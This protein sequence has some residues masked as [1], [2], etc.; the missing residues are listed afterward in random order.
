MQVGLGVLVPASVNVRREVHAAL[1]FARRRGIPP[2]NRRLQAYRWLQ[3]AA[4]L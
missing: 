4:R 1:E 3:R 2:G